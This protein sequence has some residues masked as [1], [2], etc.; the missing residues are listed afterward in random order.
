MV[1]TSKRL[2]GVDGSQGPAKPWPGRNSAAAEG[3]GLGVHGQCGYLVSGGA[4]GQTPVSS[5]P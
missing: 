3:P 1:L 2:A 4:A 5:F